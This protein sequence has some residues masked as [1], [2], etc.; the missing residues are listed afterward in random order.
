MGAQLA[1]RVPIGSTARRNVDRFRALSRTQERDG[2]RAVEVGALAGLRALA[3]I[4]RF[5]ANAPRWLG[6]L[7]LAQRADAI[8]EQWREEGVAKPSDV[9]DLFDRAFDARLVVLD[10]R[11]DAGGASCKLLAATGVRRE[12]W[13]RVD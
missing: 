13:P 11:I 5:E 6:L 7:E 8:A 2:D 10:A 12:E 4:D 3:A 9:A 1:V